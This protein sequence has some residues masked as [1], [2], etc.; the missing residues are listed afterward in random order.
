MISNLSGSTPFHVLNFAGRSVSQ[1][2]AFI[3]VVV[4]MIFS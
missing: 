2:T 1:R 4:R 3:A